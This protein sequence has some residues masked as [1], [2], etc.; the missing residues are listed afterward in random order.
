M[1]EEPKRKRKPQN[2]KRITVTLSDEQ[3]TAILKAATADDC[4]P[5]VYLSRAIK[6]NFAAITGAEVVTAA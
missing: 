3:Y 1:A 5:N 2:G 6:I 4:E